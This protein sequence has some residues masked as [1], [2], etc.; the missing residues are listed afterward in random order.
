MAANILYI[1]ITKESCSILALKPQFYELSKKR[2]HAFRHLSVF[3]G[4]CMNVVKV[5][6]VTLDLFHYGAW[7][8]L[9]GV[10]AF[11]VHFLSDI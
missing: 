10:I 3:A 2:S 9:V 8:D 11:W 4:T 7:I 1:I 5:E 6:N